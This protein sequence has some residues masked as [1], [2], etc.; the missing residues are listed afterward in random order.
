MLKLRAH[1]SP[2]GQREQGALHP[3]AELSG[4]DAK[5]T[6]EAQ[7]RRGGVCAVMFERARALTWEACARQTLDVYRA[8]IEAR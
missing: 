5:L 8:V 1:A 3:S 6:R 7:R 4:R 2:A